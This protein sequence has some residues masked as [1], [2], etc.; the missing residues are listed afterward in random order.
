MNKAKKQALKRQLEQQAAQLVLETSDAALIDDIL[1]T[2]TALLGSI[3]DLPCT[4]MTD[5]EL[6]RISACYLGAASQMTAFYAHSLEDARNNV[7]HQLNVDLIEVKERET[8][9]SGQI[10]DTREKIAAAPAEIKRLQRLLAVAEQE[11][12]EVSQQ[13]NDLKAQVD[14]KMNEAAELE[15]QLTYLRGESENYDTVIAD[16]TKNVADA[17]QA[18][19]E[20]DVQFEEMNRIRSGLQ[21]EGFVNISSFN[22]KIEE[23]NRQ[24]KELRN[25]YDTLLGKVLKDVEALRKKINSRA[26]PNG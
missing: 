16:L 10:V 19:G 7:Q 5:Q 1:R 13:R 26:M 4:G 20:L 17:E 14:E 24:S 21:E 22:K 8:L 23:M 2:C 6:A 9:L 3:K 12:N 25:Q 11:C 15:R 18:S